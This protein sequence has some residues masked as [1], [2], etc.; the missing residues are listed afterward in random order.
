MLFNSNVKMSD[1]EK[2]CFFLQ[3]YQ[4]LR[5]HLIIKSRGFPTTSSSYQA[6]ASTHCYCIQDLKFTLQTIAS[7]LW[8]GYFLK[9]KQ[10]KEKKTLFSSDAVGMFLVFLD[11]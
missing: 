11:E 5:L 7:I 4:M 3:L 8:T 2:K 9:P 10:A 1:R 6:F